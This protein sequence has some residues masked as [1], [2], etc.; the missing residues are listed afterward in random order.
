MLAYSM[1][2][3]GADRDLLPSLQRRGI[4]SLLMFVVRNIF[5]NPEVLARTLGELA[6]AGQIAQDG[7]ETERPLDFLVHANG[8]KSLTDAA[9]R[10]ARHQSGADVILF[11]TGDIGHLKD[12]VRSILAAPLPEEDVKKVR[13]MFCNLTGVGLDLPDS[14]RAKPV[15]GG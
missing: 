14:R 8:A 1:V 5:S 10:F 2:N 15:T 9:Y 3:F 4:G 12:N 6:A 11:G 7:A 13:A